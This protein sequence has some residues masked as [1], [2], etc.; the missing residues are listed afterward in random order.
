MNEHIYYRSIVQQY[1]DETWVSLPKSYST[2]FTF[3]KKREIYSNHSME[4]NVSHIMHGCIKMVLLNRKIFV[5][6]S[7]AKCMLCNGF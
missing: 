2:L 3:R 1:V 6:K 5:G 7:N 4:E